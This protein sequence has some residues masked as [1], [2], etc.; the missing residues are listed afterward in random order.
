[1]SAFLDLLSGKEYTFLLIPHP[2]ALML[3]LL[4][5]RV[6]VNI[7]QTN[8]EMFPSYKYIEIRDMDQIISF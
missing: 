8:E 6:S 4:Q 5:S 7:C 2:K 1:M 3:C